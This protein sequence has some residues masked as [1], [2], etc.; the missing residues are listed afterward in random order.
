MKAVGRQR[1]PVCTNVTS[2][3]RAEM[4]F[5]VI[6]PFLYLLIFLELREGASAQWVVA[7]ITLKY[8][9]Q[10]YVGMT[11]LVLFLLFLII[12]T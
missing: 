2:Y 7:S 6:D 11:M 8:S 3:A 10:V 4:L 12:I 5:V 1:K 9:E